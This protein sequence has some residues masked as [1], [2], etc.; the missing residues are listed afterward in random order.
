MVKPGGT[1]NLST[2][3]ISA[4]LAP[5]PPRRSFSSIG[6]RG[7]LWS[8]AKTYFIRAPE[9]SN[10]GPPSLVSRLEAELGPDRLK[11]AFDRHPD[12]FGRVTLPHGDGAVL[13]RLEVHGHRQR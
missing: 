3:V 5:L 7:C 12:L 11:H 2:D 13:E 4:R 9:G 1:G 10:G 6:G 8:K